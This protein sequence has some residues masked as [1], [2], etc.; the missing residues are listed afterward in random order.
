M[1]APALWVWD[2]SIQKRQTLREAKNVVENIQL[3]SI[4]YYGLGAPFMDNSRSSGMSRTAEEEI[5]SFSG[6]DGDIQLISWNTNKNCVATMNYQKENFWYSTGM[7][8]QKILPPGTFTGT[9]IN[10]IIRDDKEGIPFGGPP[11]G[12]PLFFALANNPCGRKYAADFV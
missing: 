10:T 3:L 9:F 1:I 7:K 11:D 4:Q 2:Q 6:A 12:V 5:R 8:N